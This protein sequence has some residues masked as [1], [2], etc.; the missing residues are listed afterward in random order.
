MALLRSELKG[1]GSA[2]RQRREDGSLGTR[3][4]GIYEGILE[5]P[6]DLA[7]E[8]LEDYAPGSMF[9]CLADKGLYIKTSRGAW[10][11]VTA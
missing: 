1:A 8:R 3:V 11:E 9:Y 5:T 4:S 10:E 7:L 6:E 2:V